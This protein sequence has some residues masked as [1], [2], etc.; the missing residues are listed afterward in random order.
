MPPTGLLSAVV[1]E[2]KILDNR[3]DFGGGIAA[4]FGV[5]LLLDYDVLQDNVANADGGGLWAHS[6]LANQI[7]NTTFDHNEALRG[8]GIWMDGDDSLNAPANLFDCLVVH[9]VAGGGLGQ[10]AG[11]FLEDAWPTLSFCTLSDNQGSSLGA[12]IA[13]CDLV[14]SLPQAVV[15]HCILWGDLAPGLPANPWEK[16]LFDCGPAF[17]FQVDFTDWEGSGAPGAPVGAGCIDAD[18]LF[19]PGG[20]NCS[21]FQCNQEYHLLQGLPPGLPVSP[22]VDAGNP[23]LGIP[24]GGLGTTNATGCLLY[25]SPSPRDQRG[26]RMPS[27]A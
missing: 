1:R 5:N 15:D 3:A 18:P 11:I 6:N 17:G 16:E 21:F 25:T 14:G 10:G 9:N 7:A 24:P 22:C 23:A 19:V 27:S 8:A 20:N 2:S 12:G 26:S 4:D 13:R